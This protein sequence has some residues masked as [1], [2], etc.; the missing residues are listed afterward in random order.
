MSD[1]QTPLVQPAVP[2]SPVFE[3][4]PPPPTP[5][6]IP[7][8]RPTRLI[9]VAITLFVLGL[10]VLVAGILRFVA[11]GIGTGAALA[12]V[13]LALFGLSFVTLP[14][15]SD[16]A[17]MSPVQK[18]T[19][20][21]FE[22]TRVFRNLRSHP[23]WLA[24]F[25]VVAILTVIYQQAFVQRITPEVIVDHYIS[26]MAEMGF[27]TPEVLSD[28]RAQQMDQLKNPVQRVGNVVKA[29]C[30]IFL[31]G[32]VLAAI[33][34]VLV[35]VFG[36]RIHFWQALA[37]YFYS[38]LPVQVIQKVLSLVILYIKDP[39]DLHPVLNQDNLVQ[40]NLGV[41]FTP[42]STPVLFVIASF[43]GVL[44]FYGLWL[45]AKGLQQGGI[46]VSSGAA[47]GVAI[48]FWLASMLF[49]S[50]ISALFPSFIS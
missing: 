42:A 3:P 12:V 24:A 38:I 15:P 10:L 36:G 50:I 39:S 33:S 46:R 29:F 22:P 6:V 37:V 26:K 44:S 18:L 27:A 47:W 5:E 28:A 8:R 20:I 19:G 25:I 13:G 34:L 45:R 32:G 48:T 41:L 43:I 23:H 40:D 21:F 7:A 30:F 17:P 2:P 9:P 16:E 1:P 4:P 14:Q 49:F 11:G 35:L 31:F